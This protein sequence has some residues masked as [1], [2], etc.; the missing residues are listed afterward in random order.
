MVLAEYFGK[1]GGS[2]QI[3]AQ[4][5]ETRERIVFLSGRTR[6][7]LNQCGAGFTVEVGTLAYR[8]LKKASEAGYVGMALIRHADI[9]MGP[10]PYPVQ[11]WRGHERI[12]PPSDR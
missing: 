4:C 9:P 7:V 10:P 6:S 11:V 5:V 12:D 2:L 8:I 3:V 1:N